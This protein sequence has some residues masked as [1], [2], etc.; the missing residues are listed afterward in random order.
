MKEKKQK[1]LKEQQECLALLSEEPKETDKN[2]TRFK[3][4]LPDDE[5]ILM[6]RFRIS[7]QLQTLFDYLT[8]QGKVF[9]EYKLL[10]TYPKRDL[11]TLNR[12]DTFEQLKLFPQEQLILENL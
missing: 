7:D 10:T 4:R 3:I 9:N 11:T 6:R 1:Q 2:I 12:S 8:S 5:G